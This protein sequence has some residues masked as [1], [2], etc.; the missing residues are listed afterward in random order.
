MRYSYITP[1]V[2]PV[3]ST[4][5][6]QAREDVRKAIKNGSVRD[7]DDAYKRLEAAD[8]V[9]TARRASAHALRRVTAILGSPDPTEPAKR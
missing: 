4:S 6:I 9:A 5:V 7:I 2:A 1:R 8:R 3:V